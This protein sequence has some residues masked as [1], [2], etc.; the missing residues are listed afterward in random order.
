VG[1]CGVYVL[2]LLAL[3]VAA[4]T[5]TGEALEGLA[6]LLVPFVAAAIL[7]APLEFYLLRR[8][9]FVYFV[10]AGSALGV[11]I[12]IMRCITPIH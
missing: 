1:L 10:P 2:P 8:L 5:A 11:A 7:F 3:A 6:M 9:P 12:I 4:V